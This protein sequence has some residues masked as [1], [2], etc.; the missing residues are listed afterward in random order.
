MLKLFICSISSLSEDTVPSFFWLT[1]ACVT[2]LSK[3]KTVALLCGSVLSLLPWHSKSLIVYRE[4]A[5]RR[6][7]K[8][9]HLTLTQRRPDLVL[10]F[11]CSCN[12]VLFTALPGHTV[13]LRVDPCHCM[14]VFHLL[15]LC[16]SVLPSLSV[17]F[18]SLSLSLF[19]M[20]LCVPPW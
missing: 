9:P 3:L 16:V 2:S 1:V 12:N 8:R 14:P 4:G 20:R 18:L 6:C 13:G 19:P 11:L 10:L 5:V 17:F 15:S 7:A